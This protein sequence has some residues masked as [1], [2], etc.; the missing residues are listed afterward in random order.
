MSS[1][2]TIL[3]TRKLPKAI[4]QRL[5]KDYTARL[6]EADLPYSPEEIITRA[7]GADA[8]LINMSDRLSAEVIHH[9]PDSVKA[10]ATF[11]VGYDNIDLAAAKQRNIAVI[12]TP[13]VLT[14]ATADLTLMLLLCAAR[15]ANE[16]NALVRSGNW[17]DESPTG[18]LG[19]EVHGKR[20]G[21]YGMGRIG[22]A[23]AQRARGFNMQIHYSNPHRLPPEEEQGATFHARPD[24]LLRV[25]DFLSFHSPATPET[26]NFLNASRMALMPKGAIVVN[27]ARG[28]LIVEADLSPTASIGNLRSANFPS[29]RAAC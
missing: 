13:G 9:L 8:L 17:N 21:I 2:P 4:E 28:T 29:F 12:N 7:Q 23:V 24:D 16:A 18:L 3:V 5:V 15:R 25:S 27:A 11:S 6:N 10:I 20:L 19:T 14:E 26:K 22:R 1:K